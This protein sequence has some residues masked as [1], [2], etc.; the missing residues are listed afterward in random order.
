[1]SLRILESDGGCIFLYLGI[2]SLINIS[3]MIIYTVVRE[4][5]TILQ[6]TKFRSVIIHQMT[7][8]GITF[9]K[10]STVKMSLLIVD[11]CVG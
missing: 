4:L 3:Q 10:S 5:F 8:R 6:D 7:T 1:M 2:E 11:R 9:Q